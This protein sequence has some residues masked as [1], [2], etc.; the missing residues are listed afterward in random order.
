[1]SAL[2]AEHLTVTCPGCGAHF[3][4][5]KESA[6]H[7]GRCSKCG[8]V[9]RM[10]PL[11]AAT[12]VPSPPPFKPAAPIA[13]PQPQFIGFECRVCQTRMYAR[14][15]QAGQSAKCPDCGARS[16]IPPPAMLRAK[17]SL[18]AAMEGEQYELW[19]VDAT[20]LASEL[21]ALQPTFIPIDCRLC[22]TLFHATVDQVGSELECPDCGTKHLVPPPIAPKSFRSLDQATGG[23]YGVD[24]SA[25]PSSRSMIV[26]LDRT[27]L[28]EKVPRA[29]VVPRGD[30]RHKK[31]FDARGRPLL[32]RWP[33]VSGIV[34][35]LFSLGV[36]VRWFALSISG[37]IAIAL[38]AS[39]AS[40]I[41]V[42]G[43]VVSL[44]LHA[45]QGVCLFVLGCVI[46][47][48][49]LAAAASIFLAIV[50]ESTEGNNRIY[51]W[52][53]ANLIEW[54]PEMLQ[55]VVAGFVCCFPGWLIAKLAPVGSIEPSMAIAASVAAM[56]PI[57]LLSQLEADSPFAVISGRVLTSLA[58]CP[59]SWL[60][61]YIEFAAIAAGGAA[62]LMF[63]LQSETWSLAALAPLY[64]AAMLL[65]A[66]LLGR[67]G[68]KLAESM[69]A[70]VSAQDGPAT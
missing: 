50:I 21:L 53:S 48:V 10:P 25:V 37:A 18:P 11:A 22:Q 43:G 28:D 31:R 2:Q 32:P 1:M 58:R 34:P 54:L 44:G 49:W 30:R 52:P 65:A 60:T 47:V 57:V 15:D 51:R 39:G 61:F 20:P 24:T 26:P 29:A 5:A 46:G 4:T 19:D 16:T 14:P 55:F 42:G 3:Q 63:V 68:W 45:I 33:L 41:G 36:P 13:E 23:P 66:R 7:R 35:F 70:V 8:L 67:L 62:A 40:S 6:G 27:V 9:F 38:A 12:A 69:P 56:L 17:K 64:V 59:F